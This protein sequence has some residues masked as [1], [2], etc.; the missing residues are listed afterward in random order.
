MTP[1]PSSSNVS[2]P[3]AAA[4]ARAMSSRSAIALARRRCGPR[5]ARRRT[6]AG[7]CRDRR[8]LPSGACGAAGGGRDLALDVGPGAEARIQQPA[9]RQRVER[10]AILRQV[11]RLH[12]HRPVPVQAQPGQVLLDRRGEFGTAAAGIDVLE[13]QQE[14][15]ARLPAPAARRVSADKAWPRCRYP[16]GLGAKRVT[17]DMRT[18]RRVRPAATGRES[19]MAELDGPRWGPASKRRAAP[20]CRAVPRPRRR[21]PRPDRPRAHLGAC[22][23]GR[24]VRLGRCADPCDD[25]G[26]GRQWWSVADRTPSVMR[27]GRAPRRRRS[28]NAVP[29]CRTG[30]PAT[31]RRTPTR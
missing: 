27:G 13:P 15:P 31:C 20:A 3:G 30:A 19:R 4:S 11:L 22:A 8:G 28:C 26:F 18:G 25:S 17:M 14:A 16:V 10:G 2:G 24:A 9:R 7:R 6:G 29:R 21:R 1:S 23:A 5:A 12:P